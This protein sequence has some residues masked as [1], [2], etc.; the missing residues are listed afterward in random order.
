MTPRNYRDGGANAEI[1]FATAA[2]S[3]G[4]VL[5]ARSDR[6]VCAISL[7]GDVE[8]LRRELQQRFP[9]ATLIGGT[10]TSNAGSPRS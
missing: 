8:A 6:G 9:K 7:G 3:L 5:V 2:C 10:R 1:R 4:R